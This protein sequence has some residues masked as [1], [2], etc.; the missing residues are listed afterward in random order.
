M[1]TKCKK[2]QMRDQKRN[3]VKYQNKK[4]EEKKKENA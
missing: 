2:M 3:F 1:Q 4:K